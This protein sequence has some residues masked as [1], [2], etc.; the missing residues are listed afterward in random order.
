MAYVPG[1]TY[2][3]FISYAHANNRDGWVRE[4]SK[5]LGHELEQLLGRQF[6]MYFDERRSEIGSLSGKL[7]AAARD[8][9]ILLPVLSPGYLQSHW[10][11][12]E[13]DAFFLNPEHLS[14]GVACVAP[15]MIRPVE[16]DDLPEP[17]RNAHRHVFVGDDGQTPL[18][19]DSDR[20]V[21]AVRGFGGRLKD[22]LRTRRLHHT[23]VY[24]GSAPSAEWYQVLRQR[25][26][27]ELENRD[28]RTLP[29]SLHV[30]KD[31][32]AIRAG[33]QRARAAVHFIGGADLIA[34]DA[35]E[36]SVKLCTGATVVFQP[37]LAELTDTERFWLHNFERS[38]E[39]VQGRYHRIDGGI[40]DELI[41]LVKDLVTREELSPPVEH[42]LALVCEK[43]DLASVRRLKEDIQKHCAIGVAYPDFLDPQSERGALS[44]AMSIRQWSEY[45]RAGKAQLFYDGAA[46]RES[47]EYWFRQSTGARR[48]WYLAEPGLAEKRERYPDALSEISH[49]S[50]FVQGARSATQ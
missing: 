45:L 8:S 12:E 29:E 44:M 16:D 32:L 11:N 35:I 23:P 15:I 2:D 21:A 49:V 17:Y 50:N 27:S 46:G 22:A 39:S 43:A 18:S 40:V 41:D 14:P 19:P 4:F 28:F 26:Q 38:L 10:C 20:W 47:L 36:T 7:T 34:L 37:R 5:A 9:A 13:R 24:V 6:E 25:C 31:A 48:E 1:C 3:V 33:L 30:R 42:Q